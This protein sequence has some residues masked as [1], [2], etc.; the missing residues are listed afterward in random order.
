MSRDIETIL[1]H[2]GEMLEARGDDI[3]EFMEHGD[4]IL[5]QDPSRY[6]DHAD[7]TVLD[8][9]NTTVIFALT[10]DISRKLFNTTFKDMTTKEKIHE[11]FIRK[12]IIIILSEMPISSHISNL[13]QKE[14][15]LEGGQ[16]QIFLKAELMYNPC[17]HELVPKHEKLTDIEIKELLEKYNLRSKAQLPTILKTDVMARWLGLRTGDIVRITRYNDTS[18]EYFFYRCCV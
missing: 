2:L 1:T 7:F 3:S 8:T 13:Q 11:K 17:K 15:L 12:N 10:K 18:G 14:K 6:T 9:D 16:I 5:Q 4:A